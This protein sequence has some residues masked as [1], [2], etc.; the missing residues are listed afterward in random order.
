MM[1]EEFTERTGIEPTADEYEVIESMYYDFNGS[2]NEFCKWF[3]KNN[4]MIQALRKLVK[5]QDANIL[6]QIKQNTA[7]KNELI[8]VQG[9]AERLQKELDAELEWQPYEYPDNVKQAHYL[10]LL[11]SAGVKILTDAEAVTLLADEFGFDPSKIRIIHEVKQIEINRH[12]YCRMVGTFERKA[13]FNAWDWNYIRFD[14]CGMSYEMD[15]GALRLF[16]W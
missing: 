3:V 7:L 5:N 9:K 1:I 16:V 8:D 12:Q 6:N 14:V 11:N 13:L 10:D 2:K 4:G 15:D